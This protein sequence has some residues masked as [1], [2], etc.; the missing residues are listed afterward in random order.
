MYVD[1]FVE[2]TASS[3][4]EGDPPPWKRSNPIKAGYA[5]EYQGGGFNVYIKRNRNAMKP[6][7]HQLNHAVTVIVQAN[8][9]SVSQLRDLTKKS[10][11]P[12]KVPKQM[13]ASHDLMERL[14]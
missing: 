5:L 3:I 6:K 2:V 1:I 9:G 14:F 13:K 8:G 7:R 10:P 11:A 4:V 12:K